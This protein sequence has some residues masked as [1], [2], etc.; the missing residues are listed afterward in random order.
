AL[1]RGDK[2]DGDYPV[3]VVVDTG[4]SNEFKSLESWVAGRDSQ[5]APQYQNPDHG[6][7]VAGLI[8]WGSML[9]P[10]LASVDSHP[11]GVFDLQ[12]IPNDDPNKGDTEALVEASFLQS[13]ETALNQYANRYKVWNLSIGT[14]AICVLEEFSALA[15]ELDNLQEK[16]KVSFVISAGN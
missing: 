2:V 8:V 7:F 10:T 11:C 13:L 16:Y 15:E 6:T 3:V 12:L 5:V 4:I 9:N 14:D 1:P